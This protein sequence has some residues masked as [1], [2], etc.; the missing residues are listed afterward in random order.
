MGDPG[1]GGGVSQEGEIVWDRGA[2]GG[3]TK[4]ALKDR[5]EEE[6]KCFDPTTKK[7]ERR[8]GR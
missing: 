5:R 1:W 6:R 3:D 2:R 4:R 8:G 7:R